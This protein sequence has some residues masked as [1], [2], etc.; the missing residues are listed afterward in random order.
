MQLKYFVKKRDILFGRLSLMFRNKILLGFSILVISL[1]TWSISTGPEYDKTTIFVRIAC[2]LTALVFSTIV[3]FALQILLHLI[4]VWCSKHRGI[5]GSHTLEI[6]DDGLEESTDI[7]KSLHRWNP[8]FSVKEF[9]NYVWIYP[10]DG[11]FFVIPKRSGGYE[12][13]L[14]GFL[15]LLKTKLGK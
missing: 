2:I 11:H 13:D 15:A 6:K 10:T 14:A 3:Y 7:N 4:M 9:G 1:L 12:G 8:S 5:E